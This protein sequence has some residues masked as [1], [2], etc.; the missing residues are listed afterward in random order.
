MNPKRQVSGL[1]FLLVLAIGGLPAPARGLVIEVPADQPTIQAGIEAAVA[2]DTVLVAPG[3][4]VENIDFLGKDIVVASR[5]LLDPIY[6]HV[7]ATIIDGSQPADPDTASTVRFVNS[8]NAAAVLQGFTITGGGGT[9][10]VDP[11][12][13]GYVWRGGGGI[14]GFRASPT[15]ANNLI[16]GNAVEND[17]SVN[18]A[19]G[20]GL[21][22]F[23]GLPLIANNTIRD[24][25]ADYGAG[26]VLEY[27]RATVRNNLVV[28]N[29]GAIIYGGGG[30][31]TLGSAATPLVLENNTIAGNG[32]ATAGGA[33]YL[34]N[35]NLV[36]RNNI[37]WGNTQPNGGPIALNNSTIDVTYSDVEGGYTG[38][39]NIDL[40][41]EFSDT[42]AYLLDPGS[43]CIDAGD[44]DTAC[45]DPEDPA[46][47]GN[48]RWPAQGTL[49]NDIGAY[50]GPGCMLFEPDASNVE[51][52]GDESFQGRLEPVRSTPNPFRR[53]TQ[54]RLSH[55]PGDIAAIEIYD[56]T[57][58]LVRS[59]R[60]DGA[61]VLWDGCD[62]AGRRLPAGAYLY[63]VLAG[64]EEQRGRAILLH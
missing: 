41:P 17:G 32:S 5:Y 62:D 58:A 18:G 23:R 51:G 31:W 28:G 64:D 36:L 9:N 11:G 38:T 26:V 21:T 30:F 14:F 2:G 10:W 59:L 25:Y 39:G 43:P 53:C 60:A 48:A 24:N 7:R 29:H 34:W 20:G 54:I 33:L 45:D 4:Y 63:R 15:I 16:T 3:R 40:P 37:I 1:L 49:R 44:P 61:E 13:P 12:V 8:E 57:G 22:F 27:S 50:G 56:P 19:Q 52:S 42:L 35:S 6:A 55:Q 47:S 46:A